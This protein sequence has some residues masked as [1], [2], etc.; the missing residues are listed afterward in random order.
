LRNL[1]LQPLPAASFFIMAQTLL[2]KNPLQPLF[3]RDF[4]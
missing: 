2:R 3:L 4:E 1:D